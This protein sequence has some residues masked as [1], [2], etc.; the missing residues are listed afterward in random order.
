[1]RYFALLD[2]Q[3]PTETINRMQLMSGSVTETEL[4][5]STVYTKGGESDRP[6][7]SRI[8]S[9]R[10]QVLPPITSPVNERQ[11]GLAA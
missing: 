2:N 3:L 9:A 5:A 1:M 6:T 11:T 7:S 10:F 8:G 4:G